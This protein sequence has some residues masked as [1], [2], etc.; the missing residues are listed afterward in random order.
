MVLAV[1]DVAKGEA[2]AGELRAEHPEGTHAVAELDT[3][4]LASVARFADRYAD[5]R[6]DILVLNSINGTKGRQESVD[7]HE[8]IMATNFTSATSR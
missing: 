2:V 3:S 6:V 5:V 4:D 1:R 7:G 8:L